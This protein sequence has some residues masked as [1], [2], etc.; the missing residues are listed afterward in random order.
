[1][2]FVRARPCRRVGLGRRT[3]PVA[4]PRSTGTSE[5]S[6]VRR[7]HPK[8]L[9]RCSQ[10]TPGFSKRLLRRRP[11]GLDLVLEVP[12]REAHAP[13]YFGPLRP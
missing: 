12:I 3:K 8:P 9:P 13:V 6:R 11:R 7:L 2:K 5:E 10:I 1:M 4:S